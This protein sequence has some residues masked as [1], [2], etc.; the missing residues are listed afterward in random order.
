MIEISSKQKIRGAVRVP[1]DKSI[2]HRGLIL[3]ALASGESVLKNLGTSHDVVSTLS[4]LKQLGCEIFQNGREITLQGRGN[5]GFIEPAKPL[6]CGNSG[7]SARLMTGVLAGQP[8]FA[9]LTGDRSLVRRPMSRVVEPLIKMGADIRGRQNHSRLP[10]AVSGGNLKAAEHKLSIASAQV[11]TALLLAGL[12]ASGTTVVTEPAQSRDHTE[13]LFQWLH[14][15]FQKEGLTC[16]ISS[17]GI[18]AFSLSIPGDF[19]S[20]AYFLALGVIHPDAKIEIQNVNLNP[21]RTGFLSILQ[22]MGAG[23][24]VETVA[25][26]PEP[27]GHI[28]VETS[29]LKNLHVPESSIPNLIDELPLLAVAATQAEG[30]LV[31]HNASELRVKE[32]DRI[33]TIVTELRKMGAAIREFSDGFEVTGPTRLTGARVKTYGDHRIA[34]SL[35]VAALMAEGTTQLLG[36]RWVQIS[37][38]AFFED[39]FRVTED[40]G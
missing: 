38:P 21:T 24:Q 1:G 30:T 31:V 15:P 10:L 37:Y 22:A 26:T 4:M 33:H 16:R 14:L 27:A 13:R 28:R 32:S 8:I 17:A 2:S 19:S 18:P 9:V 35:A 29:A 3:G 25:Y 20:A 34:M 36:D 7:T 5:R 6:F 11:K 12:R 39:L 23:I 40:T